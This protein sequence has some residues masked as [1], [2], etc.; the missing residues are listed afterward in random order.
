MPPSTRRANRRLTSS[1]DIS[2]RLLSVL[3]DRGRIAN[4]AGKSFSGRRDVAQTLGYKHTL[5]IDDYTLEYERGDIAETVVEIF[6]IEAWGE[7]FEILESEDVTEITDFEKAVSDLME[8]FD[9]VSRFIRLGILTRLGRYGT[10]LIGAKGELKTE[11]PMMSGLDD[12]MFLAPLSER[13]ARIKKI[14]D[15]NPESDR[16][17]LVE[18][19][20]VR[21]SDN[22]SKT[23]HWSRIIHTTESELEDEVYGKPA[24]RS[25]FDRLHDK[26]KIVGGGS[27]ATWAL[28][29]PGLHAKLDPEADVTPEDLKNFTDQ[30][31]DFEHKYRRVLQTTGVDLEQLESS[32]PGFGPNLHAI[33][34][35]ISGASKIPLR[36]LVGSER[37]ELA[38]TQDK[39]NWNSTVSTYRKKVCTKQIK[40]LID[41]L[42]E[43]GALPTPNNSYRVVWPSVEELDELE[44]SKLVVGLAEANKSQYEAEGSIIVSAREIRDRLGYY[45][46]LEDTI[47][48]PTT[49]RVAA[50]YGDSSIPEWRSVH[51]AADSNRSTVAAQ[52]LNLWA[53]TSEAL[54]ED[55]LVSAINSGSDIKINSALSAAVTVAE[56][57]VGPDITNAILKTL[58][59]AGLAALKSAK[60]R[61]SFFVSPNTLGEV[62]DNSTP[63]QEVLLR[64]A[65]ELRVDLTFNEANP[66]AIEWAKSRSS[67]LVTEV[68]AETIEA[69]KLIIAQGIEDGI[70]PRKL[71][72][73]IRKQVGLLPDQVATLRK[74]E[75]SLKNAKPGQLIRSGKTKIR[76]PK[77]G[78]TEKQITEKLARRHSNLLNYRSLRIGRTE[79][80]RSANQGQKELWLQGVDSGQIDRDQMRI[81]IVTD[82]GR[83]RDK[84]ARMRNQLARLDEPF[85]A[86][87]GS[88]LEPGEDPHCRCAQGLVSA[89]QVKEIESRLAI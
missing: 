67:E 48:T 47:A 75:N 59:S 24:L 12:I 10:M 8:R 53:S 6:P 40:G 82:D 20:D 27:E 13:R 3:A 58:N 60:A 55:L 35:L 44:K 78:F 83:L 51:K 33:L 61:G 21:L 74:L 81:W 45:A 73:L 71:V 54:D 22:L 46:D 7:G 86:P 62:L 17:G 49:A 80:M 28:A 77:A 66:R 19:Y 30:L 11:L 25:I 42:I 23:A 87:D 5:N 43:H 85:V 63:L 89:Q 69:L 32:V 2:L 4:R 65:D 41:R 39:N 31:E 70:P 68:T 36:K 52:F 50:D 16:F 56:S 37:G 29:K 64:G 57:D 88:D 76:V 9:L 15:T 1:G 38:S 79:V 84:H 14:N 34:K 26:A 72:A 18:T